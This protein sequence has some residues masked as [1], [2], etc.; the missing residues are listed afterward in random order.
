MREILHLLLAEASLLPA[1]NPRPRLDVGDAVLALAVA[2]QVLA[3][4]AGEFAREVDFQHAVDAQGFVL[5]ARDG[6]GDFFR[7]GAR[8]VVYLACLGE[9]F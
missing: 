9:G 7:G 8:E 2:G 1:L 3:G 5:E 4:F 6:V